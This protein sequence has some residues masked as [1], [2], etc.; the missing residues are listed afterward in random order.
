MLRTK[1]TSKLGTC[2]QP[3][4]FETGKLF[5]GPKNEARIEQRGCYKN[6]KI[7][8]LTRFHLT[9]FS[10][11]TESQVDSR[12]PMTDTLRRKNSIWHLVQIIR[13]PLF[14]LITFIARGQGTYVV[15][16]S[17][18]IEDLHTKEGSLMLT[19]ETSGS[20]CSTMMSLHTLVRRWAV[21]SL[22]SLCQ[23]AGNSP[24]LQ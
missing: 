14:S 9:G 15:C 24:A 13:S 18:G 20:E 11:F 19:P 21:V 8:K 23:I 10:I 1:I 22:S 17:E 2:S 6:R 4:R 12:K 5:F 3:L 16:Q 7:G